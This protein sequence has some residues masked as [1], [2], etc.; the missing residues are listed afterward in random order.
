MYDVETVQYWIMISVNTAEDFLCLVS[1]CLT[2]GPYQ[3]CHKSSYGT[4]FFEL[5]HSWHFTWNSYKIN[6]IH[7][8]IELIPYHIYSL[9]I[10]NLLCPK[11]EIFY[12]WLEP[13]TLT[14]HLVKKKKKI[15]PIHKQNSL[16][17][18]VFNTGTSN[19][20]FNQ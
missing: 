17:S 2:V 10:Q 4:W 20:F 9:I 19:T 14:S 18:T 6:F 12:K 7:K 1:K 5:N 16:L 11:V 13:S 15:A 3:H 8:I